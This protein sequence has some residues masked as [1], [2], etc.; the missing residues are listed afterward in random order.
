MVLCCYVVVFYTKIV[1]SKTRTAYPLR[2][3]VIVICSER[4]PAET[5]ANEDLHPDNPAHICFSRSY[6]QRVYCISFGEV[7]L[8]ITW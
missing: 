7:D 2:L 5:S 3:W 8:K 1:T 4:G 6:I